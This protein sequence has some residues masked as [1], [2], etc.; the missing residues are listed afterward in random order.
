[1]FLHNLSHTLNQRKQRVQTRL[2]I[3]ANMEASPATV[4]SVEGH[5]K[6]SGEDLFA[7]IAKIS[8]T[9]KK[10]ASDDVSMIKSDTTELEN[11]ASASQTR[12]D[13]AESCIDNVEDIN[14]S[15]ANDNKVLY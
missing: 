5:Q 10:V 11:A 13:E 3:A 14:T 2:K 15:I 9:L 7:E 4:A 6:N 1:M 8:T 12:L